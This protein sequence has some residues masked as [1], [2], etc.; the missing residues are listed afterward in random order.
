MGEGDELVRRLLA[1]ATAR[2]E[3]ADESAITGQDRG[4]RQTDHRIA[5][6]LQQAA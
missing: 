6:P 5:R 4:L 2:L 1:T 3:D